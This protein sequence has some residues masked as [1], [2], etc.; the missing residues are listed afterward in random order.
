MDRGAIYEEYSL[1]RLAGCHL[2]KAKSP[3]LTGFCQ[4]L[5]VGTLENILRTVTVVERYHGQLP[6]EDLS[7]FGRESLS[8]RD[9]IPPR[10]FLYP[11][12]VSQIIKRR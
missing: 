7:V 9:G 3:K 6:S 2:G 12:P 11:F 5:P 8:S 1:T 10:L 4:N